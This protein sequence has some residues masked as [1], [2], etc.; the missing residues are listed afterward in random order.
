MAYITAELDHLEV[1]S[2]DPGALAGFYGRALQMDVTAVH[3]RF[4]CEGR[5][6][7]M[8]MAAGQAKTL[9]YLALR[10]AS[11][12]S[13]ADLRGRIAAT[14]V[15]IEASPSPF[16]DDQA[17]SVLDPDGNRVAF[18][19]GGRN[20]HEQGLTARLQHL[21]LGTTDIGRMIAF[22][23]EVVGLRPSDNVYADDDSLRSTFLRAGSEHHV[24]A[25]FQAAHN[26]F[27][28]HCYE[29]ETW[30]LIRDWADYLATQDI[31]LD[32]GPGRHGPG[33]NLFFMIRDP[34]QN[35]LEI[36]A[37]LEIV[38]AD[39]PVGRWVHCEKTLNSWGKAYLRS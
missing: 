25:I 19:H 31:P 3:D 27:D 38:P 36:S 23:T 28:H 12:Q 26:T 39:R 5:H 37:E 1:Q 22:Y 30:D 21:A 14:G 33:N 16:F 34:D 4:L 2:P 24:L 18:G 32:W 15:A 29:A 35:W 9:N 17:F 13:L 11:A 10:L 6:R 8:A 7:R 20:S